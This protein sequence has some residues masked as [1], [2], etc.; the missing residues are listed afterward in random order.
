[1]QYLILILLCCWGQPNTGTH[2]KAAQPNDLIQPAAANTGQQLTGKWQW[3]KS[4][5]Q[6]KFSDGTQQNV[7]VK[8]D[9]G[10]TVAFK[11][12]ST[13]L[14]TSKGTMVTAFNETNS[15]GSWTLNESSLLLEMTQTAIDG[16]PAY[17]YR[18]V[19]AIS[20]N[21]LTLTADD[22]MIVRQFTDNKLAEFGSKKVSGGS[23]TETYSK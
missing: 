19:S 18:K 4:T 21:A 3:V 15:N 14:G 22:A 2:H 1:M 10:E 7:T 17:S 5:I 16:S 8:G 11:Y 6:I 13:G 20:N 23:I 9:P 12:G